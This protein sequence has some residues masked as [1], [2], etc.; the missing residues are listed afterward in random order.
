MKQTALLL[1]APFFLACP[2]VTTNEP[3]PQPVESCSLASPYTFYADGLRRYQERVTISA[4][5]EFSITRNFSSG[6]TA[7]CKA[8][9]ACNKGNI[10]NL[11]DIKAAFAHPDVVK[12]FSAGVDFY[13]QDGRPRDIPAFVIEGPKGK[14]QVGQACT[15]TLGGCV[16]IPGGVAT[17]V[18][19]LRIVQ[20]QYSKQGDCASLPES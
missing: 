17:L 20:D 11:S 16:A 4:K 2:T 1:L 5:G 19:L 18:D 7:S 13:G 15:T 10:L 3:R 9:I 14:L 12:A 6:K 8:Q